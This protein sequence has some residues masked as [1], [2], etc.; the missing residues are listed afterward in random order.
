MKKLFSAFVFLMLSISTCYAAPPPPS[1]EDPCFIT[2]F[3]DI[4]SGWYTASNGVSVWFDVMAL[5]LVVNG[6][7]YQ[8]YNIECSW[9]DMPETALMNFSITFNGVEVP[10]QLEQILNG[11]QNLYY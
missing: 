3:T 4:S 7:A 9:D 2:D 10:G 11:S 6:A 8:M 5:E 1:I